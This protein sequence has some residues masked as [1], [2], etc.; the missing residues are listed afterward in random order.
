V[1]GFGFFGETEKF[2]ALVPSSWSK[3]MLGF[4]IHVIR[5]HPERP[6]QT[7]PVHDVVHRWRD[8]PWTSAAE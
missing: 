7:F 5:L 6:T 3:P 1:N 8:V 4:T 2:L